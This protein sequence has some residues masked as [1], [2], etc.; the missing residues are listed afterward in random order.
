MHKAL[1]PGEAEF[2]LI[3][4]KKMTYE[5]AAELED[6]IIDALRRYTHF[7]VDLSRVL[8]IDLCGSHLLGLLKC[9]TDKGLVIVAT[10][11]AVD[12]AYENFIAPPPCV[13]KKA[14]VASSRKP[15][16]R[17]AARRLA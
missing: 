11:P 17:K 10:S 9:F 8:E 7:E 14:P 2:R 13:V 4:G 1:T 5:F 15:V 6:K 16:R 12:L 3:F